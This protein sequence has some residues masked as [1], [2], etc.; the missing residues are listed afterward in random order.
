MREEEWEEASL[1]LKKCSW[2]SSD[3]YLEEMGAKR[4]VLSK[5]VTHLDSFFPR[6]TLDVC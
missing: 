6:V 1:G 2:I 3:L 4:R 5:R